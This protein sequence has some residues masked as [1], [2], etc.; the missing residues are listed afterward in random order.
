MVTRR[1]K[2][3]RS[4]C[5]VQEQIFSLYAK[6]LEQGKV[7]GMHKALGGHKVGQGFVTLTLLLRENSCSYNLS[8]RKVFRAQLLNIKGIIL[9]G[10]YG[11]WC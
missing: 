11:I 5:K 3:K 9:E 2:I 4:V 7:S 6:L 8:C 10:R 1:E